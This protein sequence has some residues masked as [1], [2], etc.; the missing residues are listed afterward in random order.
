[1]NPKRDRFSR[2]FPN[3]VDILRDTLRKIA[4]CSN[5]ASYEWDKD[6][7]QEAF[8]LIGEE[9]TTTA[10]CFGVGFKIEVTHLIDP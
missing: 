6:K 9:F 8:I 4:N 2:M 10:R 7:V 1:M 5:K 3:R